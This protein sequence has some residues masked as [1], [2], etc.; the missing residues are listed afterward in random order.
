MT[1]NSVHWAGENDPASRPSAV[2]KSGNLYHIK[3]PIEPVR[4]RGI[5]KFGNLRAVPRHLL[6]HHIFR[7]KNNACTGLRHKCRARLPGLS[8]QTAA[9][10]ELGSGTR[11]CRQLRPAPD[12]RK[13]EWGAVCRLRAAHCERSADILDCSPIKPSVFFSPLSFRQR[14][15]FFSRSEYKLPVD[16]HFLSMLKQDMHVHHPIY[17][18]AS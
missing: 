3:F 8:G 10:G 13:S 6:L 12:R 14:T 9:P 2:V 17:E 1:L 16:F 15:E 7:L 4:N 5:Q 18:R 11:R